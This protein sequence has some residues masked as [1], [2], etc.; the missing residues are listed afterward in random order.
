MK[1]RLST[2][3]LAAVISIRGVGQ[4]SADS[5][6]Y[7]GFASLSTT[8]NVFIDP[9]SYTVYSSP[10]VSFTTTDNTLTWSG[11]GSNEM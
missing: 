11:D 5:A 1:P 8:D 7:F 2:I 4:A 9:D 3:A 6:Q 10:S